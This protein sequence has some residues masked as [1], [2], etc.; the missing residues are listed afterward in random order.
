M[1]RT[2]SSFTAASRSQRNGARSTSSSLRKGS[3]MTSTA[4][5]FTIVAL[6][7]KTSPYITMSAVMSGTAIRMPKCPISVIASEVPIALAAMSQ[8]SRS[9]R[10]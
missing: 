9:G 8:G 7:G 2:P 6:F 1:K 3:D 4:S 5:E 10:S